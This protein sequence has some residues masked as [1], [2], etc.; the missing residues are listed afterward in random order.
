MNVCDHE[1]AVPV[2]MNDGKLNPL[3]YTKH[4]QIDSLSTAALEMW[5]KRKIT[6]AVAQRAKTGLII[7]PPR[8]VAAK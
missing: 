5:G 8:T 3:S 6:F 2:G 4:N 7:E 1:T